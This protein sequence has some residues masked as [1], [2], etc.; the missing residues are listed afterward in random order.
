VRTPSEHYSFMQLHW[1]TDERFVAYR[2]LIMWLS[3]LISFWCT[4]TILVYVLCFYFRTLIN[5][6]TSFIKLAKHG[7]NSLTKNDFYLLKSAELFAWPVK[8]YMVELPSLYGWIPP[9]LGFLLSALS[10]AC[11]WPPTNYLA[12]THNCHEW[13]V[14]LLRPCVYDLWTAKAGLIL[15]KNIVLWKCSSLLVAWA[16]NSWL[17]D[18]TFKRGSS[19][20]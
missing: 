7:L 8:L 6:N 3:I 1:V 12:T 20:V 2:L 18:Q 13:G 4:L 11:M 9:H 17:T 14:T 15:N 10:K 16:C 19:Q 5:Y